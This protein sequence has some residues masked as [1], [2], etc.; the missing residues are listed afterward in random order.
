MC[1]QFDSVPGHSR[2]L[3]FPL[4]FVGTARGVGTP[5]YVR[6]PRITGD[7]VQIWYR[8]TGGVVPLRKTRPTSAGTNE[9]K[10][11]LRSLRAKDQQK[12]A[13]SRLVEEL[14]VARQCSA[15][16]VPE[17]QQWPD[18][19]LV[20]PDGTRLPV[21]VVGAYWREPGEDPRKGSPWKRAHV[22]AEREANQRTEETGTPHHFGAH[23]DK[24]WVIPAD[25]HSLLPPTTQPIRPD[26]WILAA[27]EQ[28]ARKQYAVQSILLVD[29]DH[30]ETPRFEDWN[31]G[32]RIASLAAGRF[33]EVWIV[34]QYSHIPKRF[35]SRLRR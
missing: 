31:L 8:R 14:A 29:L 11:R 7:M 6:Y 25:G 24:P 2:S 15:I 34:D 28:K 3:Q 9:E 35:F 32:E 20:E 19:F 18:G 5:G 26:L 1:R 13:E 30:F 21:E 16:A 4:I 17:Q 27:V 33:L 12:L 22:E 10:P 23:Y